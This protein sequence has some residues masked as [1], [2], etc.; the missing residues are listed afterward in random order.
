MKCL[1]LGA[2][3]LTTP[4]SYSLAIATVASACGLTAGVCDLGDLH[5]GGGLPQ[6]R[7]QH[8]FL[9]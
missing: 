9:H 8:D 1:S 7:G 2:G 5:P 4:V 6:A 3:G